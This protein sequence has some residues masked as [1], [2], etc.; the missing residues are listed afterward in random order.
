MATCTIAVRWS[1][2]HSGKQSAMRLSSMGR[3][4]S[5][6]AKLQQQYHLSCWTCKAPACCRFCHR[7]W[8]PDSWCCPFFRHCIRTACLHRVASETIHA[9]KIMGWTSTMHWEN[10]VKWCDVSEWLATLYHQCSCLGRDMEYRPG[11]CN[12]RMSHSMDSA[13]KNLTFSYFFD[14]GSGSP[15]SSPGWHVKGEA[16]NATSI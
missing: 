16:M 1:V 12:L 5:G 8:I 7:Q 15:F 2:V 14:A 9:T 6:L 13:P 10:G 4:T 11:T 3:V